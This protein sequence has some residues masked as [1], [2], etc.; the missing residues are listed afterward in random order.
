MHEGDAYTCNIHFPCYE[1]FI[2][3]GLLHARIYHFLVSGTAVS[4]RSGF[5]FT[6]VHPAF[7]ILMADVIKQIPSSFKTHVAYTTR[8]AIQET[9]VTPSSYYMVEVFEFHAASV[10]RKL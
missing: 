8:V 6:L 4:P 9:W 7:S 5:Y 10:G 1:I 3:E 2:C